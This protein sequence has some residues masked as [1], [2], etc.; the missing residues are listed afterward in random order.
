MFYIAVGS[1]RFVEF[2]PNDSRIVFASRICCWTQ[3]EM[4]AV[5]EQR[6]SK[7][8]FVDSVFPALKDLRLSEN[9]NS[10]FFKIE[11]QIFLAKLYHSI[12]IDLILDGQACAYYFKTFINRIKGTISPLIII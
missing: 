12:T 2:L 10:I 9:W 11:I 6:Y 1:T 8:N 3:V 5:T 4:L 7:M